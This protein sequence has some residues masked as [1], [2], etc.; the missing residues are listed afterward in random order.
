[1]ENMEIK[2]TEQTIQEMEKEKTE[3]IKRV[4]ET[5]NAHRQQITQLETTGLRM[6]GELDLLKK[7]K[8]QLKEEKKG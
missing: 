6:Q 3:E 1:M 7:L 2:L 4:A 5:I 8:E